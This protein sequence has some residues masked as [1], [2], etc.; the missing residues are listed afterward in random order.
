[1][2]DFVKKHGFNSLKEFHKLVSNVDISDA[3]KLKAFKK[4]QYEDGSKKGLLKLL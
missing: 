1:M 4:W 3:N 2:E